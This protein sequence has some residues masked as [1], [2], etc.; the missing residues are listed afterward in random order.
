MAYILSKRGDTNLNV[1]D[2]LS[3]SPTRDVKDHFAP[4]PKP[5]KKLKTQSKLWQPPVDPSVKTEMD[6]AIADFIH[7]RQYDFQTAEDPKF[8]RI[9]CLARRLPQT[10]EPPSVYKVGGELLLK[11]YD[12]N[13]EQETK[14]LLM[15]SRIYGISLYGDGATIATTPMINAL[16]TGV[17]NSFAMLDVFDCTEHMAA[18]GVKDAVYIAGLF[19]PI[20]AKLE[21][22]TDDFVSFVFVLC[23]EFN[24]HNIIMSHIYSFVSTSQE[25]KYNGVVD[26]VFFDGASNVQKAGAIIEQ[27]N[28]RISSLCAAEHTTS[29]FFDNL[30]KTI[31]IYSSLSNFCKKLRNV[32]GSVRHGP[33]SMFKSH[34]KKHN[35]G[36]HIGFIKPSDCR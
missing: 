2:V 8:K 7:S 22:M 35:R 23:L 28:P 33:A 29:L 34:S 3:R 25:N 12:I 36:I 13:W 15:E 1:I 18:G 6:V 5:A 17:H 26:V 10:Y 21:D 9:I 27:R 19:V 20:I 30:F 11:L 31:P 4:I 16:G 32:F 14:S 24:Y